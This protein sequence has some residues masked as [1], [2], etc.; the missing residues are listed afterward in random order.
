MNRT[1]VGMGLK[2]DDVG[3]ARQIGELDQSQ[4]LADLRDAGVPSRQRVWLDMQ[5]FNSFDRVLVVRDNRSGKYVGALLV[6]N[7]TAGK[8]PFLVIEALSGGPVQRDEALLKRML[9]YLILRLETWEERPLA[10]LARTRNP[11]LCRVLRRVSRGI[12][13]ASFYPEPD[14]SVISMRTAALAHR[15]AR[16][17]GPD[18]RFAEARLAL[19]TASAD[20][21]PDRPM[22]AVLDLRFVN[23]AALTEEGR[24][25]FR[26]RLPRSAT[27]RPMAEVLML[28]GAGGNG[29]I[30]ALPAH[31]AA[32]AIRSAP[33][34]PASRR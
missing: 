23:E 12:Q 17:A 8:T 13:D 1:L 2:L 18:H 19:H 33:V 25:L 30:P 7:Q 6:Q 32:Q 10:I 4:I 20:A 27:K 24:H 29:D 5:G 3:G 26:D 16:Q 28:P 11:S 21:S 22:V 15:I 9:A 14:G 31:I 34:S